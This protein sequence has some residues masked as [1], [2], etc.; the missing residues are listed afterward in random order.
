M[1]P[2]L[3]AVL[4]SWNL[5]YDVIIMLVLFTTIYVTGWRRLTRRGL[6]RE[7]RRD[8]AFYLTSQGVIALALL[9]PIDSLGAFL[10]TAHMVQHELLMMAG[11]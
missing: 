4:L 7:R 9:S 2:L 8:C 5:R 6:M 10:F 11:A 3:K 1:D